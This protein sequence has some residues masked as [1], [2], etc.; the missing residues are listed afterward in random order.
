MTLDTNIKSWACFTDSYYGNKLKVGQWMVYVL[1]FTFAGILISG[2]A[3]SQSGT[4]EQTPE[5]DETEFSIDTPDITLPDADELADQVMIRRTD[6]GVPHIK[7]DNYSSAG[8][9]FG[10]IQ[11]EDHGQEVVETFIQARGEFAMHKEPKISELESRIDSDAANRLDYQRAVETYYKLEDDTRAFMEGFAAGVNR[12]IKNY[13][14]EFDEWVNADITPFDL[15]ARVIGSPSRGSIRQFLSQ[16][17]DIEK[18]D[19]PT[20]LIN[21]SAFAH[22]PESAGNTT[23]SVQ[24][25]RSE[26]PMDNIWARLAVNEPEDLHPEAGSNAWAFGSERT[27]SGN[28]ILMRNPHLSWNAGYYEAQ[29]TIPGELNFY[30][31]FRIGRALGIIGGFNENLGFATTNNDTDEEEIYAFKADPDKPDHFIVD[32]ESVPIEKKHVEVPFRHGESIGKETREFLQSPYGPVIHRGNGLVYIIKAGSDGEYR[33]GEQF[34]NM[35]RADNLHEWQDAMRMRAHPRSNLLYADREGNAF[36]VW[37]GTVPSLPHESG[38]DT[39]ATFVEH[40]DEMWQDIIEWE[41]LPQLLNPAGGYVRNENDTFHFTNLNQVM[42]P[43]NY[44]DN[45]PEPILRLRSQHSLE[46]IHNDETFSLEDIVEMKHSMRMTLADRVK[47]DLVEAVRESEPDNEVEDAIEM[48]EEWDNTVARESKGSLLFSI[49]WEGYRD[50]ADS[51]DNQEST[52]ES[53]GF[54]EHADSLFAQPWD[55]ESPMDTPHGLANF[56]AAVEAFEWAIEETEERHGAWD[57]KWGDVHRAVI[58]DKDVPVGGCSGMLGCFRVIWYTDHED[59]DKKRQVRG[60][61]GWVSAVEFGDVPKAYT[62][63]AYGQSIKE[64]SPYYNNQLELFADN[65]MTRVRFTEEDIRNN[66]IREYRPGQEDK[67]ASE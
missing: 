44:P 39:T 17:E 57:L 32:G 59:D 40:P 11:L 49:W 12:Y 1:T 31:D 55:I 53:V 26:I 18:K 22:A 62:I 28:A 37:N 3:A 29:V 21:P 5:V 19:D 14:D 56:N 48:I 34:L 45:F 43:E 15:H 67:P 27:E 23:S 24:D 7:A 33:A 63:L 51:S 50:K 10:Y 38:N 42:E 58:G 60:G 9:A 36:Y 8:Y 30:G 61:D 25:T 6:H 47:G 13:P 54:S 20:G 16:L 4:D 52:P 66:I 41:A 46:L 2:C 35:M 65:Q 64:D